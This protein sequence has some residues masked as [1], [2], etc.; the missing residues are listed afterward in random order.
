MAA[1]RIYLADDAH[2]IVKMPLRPRGETILDLSD[3]LKVR[4]ANWRQHRS[5]YAHVQKRSDGERHHVLLHREIMD[6]PAADVDHINRWKA[7]NRRCNLRSATRSQNSLNRNI[8][9]TLRYKGVTEAN[10]KLGTGRW[11]ARVWNGTRLVGLGTY[12]TEHEAAAAYDAAAFEMHGEFAVL[13][14]P[15]AVR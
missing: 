6:F 2:L 8:R 4:G 13:N 1:G 12:A 5:G 15:K 11:R 3:W 7:D 10:P 9:R 14:F